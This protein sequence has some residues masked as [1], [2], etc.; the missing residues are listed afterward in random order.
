VGACAVQEQHETGS[1]RGCVVPQECHCTGAAAAAAERRWWCSGCRGGLRPIETSAK[2]PGGKRGAHRGP[3]VKG[4]AAQGGQRR[5]SGGGSARSSVIGS[6]RACSGLLSSTGRRVESLRSQWRGQPGRS[7]T[8]GGQLPRWASSHETA[9]GLNSVVRKGE[10]RDQGARSRSWARDGA[11]EGV[12]GGCSA[13]RRPVHGGVGSRCGGA[14]QG[15]W[16]WG[17]MVVAV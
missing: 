12:L 17:S 2:G 3:N 1:E 6:M 8:D 16:R 7:S 10:G 13:P 11:P 14:K 9:S 4:A 5:G 15:Q